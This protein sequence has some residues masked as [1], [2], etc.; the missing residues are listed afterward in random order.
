MP[1]AGKGHRGASGEAISW[2]TWI[3]AMT[4]AIKRRQGRPARPRPDA[5]TFERVAATWRG[6]MSAADSAAGLT[7]PSHGPRPGSTERSVHSCESSA[8]RLA[9]FHRAGKAGGAGY[10]IVEA[11]K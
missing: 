10:E 11:G 5:R 8:E 2:R 4:E 3:E 9:P 1:G 6:V 7:V